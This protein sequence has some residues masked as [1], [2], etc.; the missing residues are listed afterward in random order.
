MVK[1]RGLEDYETIKLKE[2]CSAILQTKLP[3]KVKDSISFTILCII[4][5]STFE[6]AL[7]DLGASIN[8]MP[9]SMFQKLGLGEVKPTTISLQMI[10]RS[11]TY[12][13]GVIED[14]LVKVGKFIFL[15]DF[16]VLDI[17]EDRE[18][19]LI[20]GRPFL[21]MGRALIS[22]H[23]GNLT[24][25]V[26]DEEIQFNTYHTMK[27]PDEGQSCNRISVLDDCVKGVVG[28]VLIDDPLE[29]YLVHFSFR[30]SSLSA[31]EVEFSGY[32]IEDEQLE[33]AL[34]L[35]YL[36]S[37]NNHEKKLEVTTPVFENSKSQE[38]PYGSKKGGIGFETVAQ[39]FEVCL[40]GRPI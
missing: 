8:L 25:H 26:N 11:L 22:V 1:K 36:P 4:G 13:R 23:I 2:E 6:K 33:C 31:S 10:N 14:V 16:M 35:D 20:F 28:G 15:V 30:K 39:S 3:Q 17:E 32:D 5:D 27:F 7:C 38:E 12:P 21:T 9:L 34:A 29:H 37:E 24:L 40:L 19:P 18:I